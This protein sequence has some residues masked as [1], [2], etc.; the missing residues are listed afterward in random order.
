MNGFVKSVFISLI[1]VV[2]G[3]TVYALDSNK[4]NT[5]QVVLQKIID[6][7]ELAMYY[8]VDT[9]PERSPL[10]IVKNSQTTNINLH[11]FGEKV[12]V[13]DKQ[14]LFKANK[15]YL[16]FAKIKIEKD[17][18]NVIFV[19]PVEGLHGTVILK[20]TDS[21]WQIVSKKITEH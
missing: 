18:A 16:E 6:M 9:L 17:M 5:I 2:F 12:L 21:Q 10:R 13:E 20:R 1:F 15:P 3:I 11:K 7:K 4:D 14:S 8:H 19:Y